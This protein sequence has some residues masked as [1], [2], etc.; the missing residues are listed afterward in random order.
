MRYSYQ[1]VLPD[2]RARHRRTAR[3]DVA[4]TMVGIFLFFMWAAAR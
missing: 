1:P 3:I 2:D 4:L